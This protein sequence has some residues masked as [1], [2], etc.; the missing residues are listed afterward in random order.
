MREKMTCEVCLSAP[1]VGNSGSLSTVNEQTKK[2]LKKD[3]MSSTSNSIQ[4]CPTT[5]HLKKDAISCI[6]LEKWVL[7]LV[8]LTRGV[9]DF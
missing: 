7:Q 6:V 1:P 9:D 8:P 2:S 3:L 4:T 5:M